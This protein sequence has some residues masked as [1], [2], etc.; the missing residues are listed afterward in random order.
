MRTRLA[1]IG[2]AC[3]LTI[4]SGCAP[5]A[6][7]GRI[8]TQSLN[9]HLTPNNST[10]RIALSPIAMPIGAATMVVDA[11]VL[12]PVRAL[13]D[14]A[15]L[16][17]DAFTALEPV[18]IGEVV[19]LPLRTVACACTFVA[20]EVAWITMPGLFESRTGDEDGE[21]DVEGSRPESEKKPGGHS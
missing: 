2:A 4:T 17:G 6:P 14:A 16:A 7:G 8:L 18:G 11:V 20:I 1:S 12:N 9:T 10:A 13:P 15:D 5:F 19:V 21:L 3:L